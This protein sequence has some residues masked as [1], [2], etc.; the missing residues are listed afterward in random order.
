[1]QEITAD[2]KGKPECTQWP[3]AAIALAVFMSTAMVMWGLFGLRL[4]YAIDEGIWFDGARRILEGQAPYR[5]FFA[6]VGPGA[7]WNTAAAFKVFGVTL[8][9]ARALLV[10]DLA[11]IA[12]CLYWI[13]AQ[14]ESRT[15]GLLLAVFFVS[16]MLVWPSLR[17]VNH[18][19]DSAALSVAAVALLLF[20]ARSGPNWV[21]AAGGALAG[22][23]AWTTPSMILVLVPMLCWAASERRCIGVGLF[24]AGV[25][26][27]SAVAAGA[28]A[29][30]GALAPMV[31]S[32]LWAST[33]YYAPNRF[34]YGGMV[35]GYGEI[36]SD[37]HDMAASIIAGLIAMLIVLPALSPI[38]AAAG[39][40]ISRR[41]RTARLGWL[42]A[43]AAA[44]LATV[45]PRMDVRH[46][47][48]STALSYVIATCALMRLPQRVRVALLIPLGAGAVCMAY[49]AAVQH[50]GLEKIESRVGTLL[51]NHIE[52]SLAHD[53]E[54]A[55][56]PGEGFFSF[57]YMP[58]AYFL[59]QG[60]NPT[61]YSYLQPG[62]MTDQDEDIALTS[63]R[64]TPPR[65]ILYFDLKPEFLLRIW[66]GTHPER[67]R[68]N[69]IERWLWANYVPE[70]RFS[71]EHPGYQLLVWNGAI[72]R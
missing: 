16:E 7:F 54:Q 31:R 67:V 29:A 48:Y 50:K 70:K 68:L 3:D 39:I 65:K 37:V 55:V 41:M 30:Q 66:P 33:N 4:N 60:A 61:R 40:V 58:F 24:A 47:A 62:M 19:W 56:A 11:L 2:T 51:G 63:L 28:L 35:G 57:P 42:A 12:A 8:G 72:G 13:M 5:D 49:G 69:K 26:S 71:H 6:Y 21:W 36:F 27:V 43:C 34:S 44:E 20:G 18:R 25:A 46:I 64:L 45:A 53:L 52:L 32:M 9:A 59:T 10:V 23:A 15:A 14:L 38:G 17:A 1:M 22:Y